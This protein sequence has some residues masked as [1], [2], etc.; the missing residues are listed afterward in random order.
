MRKRNQS[1]TIAM[2]L[3]TITT[4]GHALGYSFAVPEHLFDPSWP[5]H[6]RFHVL[7]ALIGVIGIDLAIL[8]LTFGP[9]QRREQW[10]WWLV[11]ILLIFAQ[12]GYFLA[13]IFIPEGIT[14]GLGVNLV[15]VLSIILWGIG[16]GMS[17]R[18]MRPA[19]E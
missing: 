13:A 14:P 12:G 11:G 7:Q 19:G 4:I 16:L 8:A 17:Y 15:Y 3:I 5:D 18:A 6:A 10:A 2:A 1:L 9:F